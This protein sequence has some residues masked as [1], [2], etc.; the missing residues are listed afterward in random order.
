MKSI[1]QKRKKGLSEIV[2]VVIIILL[3][4]VATTIVWRVVT[5]LVN[6]KTENAQ[7]CFNAGLDQTV[8][9]NNDYTCYNS[10]SK[11]LQFSVNV[12]D[13]DIESITV[14]IL[15]GGNSKTFTLGNA[16][17]ISGLFTY[18]SRGTS[19]KMPDKSGGLTYIATGI[20]QSPDWVRI[21]PT[22]NGKQCDVTDTIYSPY[23]CSLFS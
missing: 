14:S 23:D 4:I 7:S 5:N 10:T 22:V 16:T 17:T 8:T 3:V 15:Y 6:S 18:P 12:G 13:I 19:I 21:A 11:E 1:F 20:S 2:A 9:L